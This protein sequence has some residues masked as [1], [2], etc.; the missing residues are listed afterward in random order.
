MDH[1]A[2]CIRTGCQP[3]TPGEEGL[4]GQ[5]LMEAIY[6]A[7]RGSRADKLPTVQGLN[8]TRSPA[9]QMEADEGGIGEYG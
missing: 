6:Q 9:P 5:K 7:A 1:F 4:H 3:H 2:D 8:T